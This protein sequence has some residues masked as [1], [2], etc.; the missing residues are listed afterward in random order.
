M[1][2]RLEISAGVLKDMIK[3]IENINTECIWAF[4]PTGLY[5]R[6]SD[7]YRYKLLELI[8]S[9]EDM[10]S[11]E[12]SSNGG[13][14]LGIVID[15]IKDIS[16]TLKK[17]DTLSLYYD[18]SEPYIIV[19]ANA[20]KR[21]VKLID[22]KL[23]GEPPR[24]NQ[25]NDFKVIIDS[26]RLLSFLKATSK[27]ISFDLIT[28]QGALHAISETDEGFSEMIWDKTQYPVIPI[29]SAS[30]TNYSVNEVQKAVCAAKGD[31]IVRGGM[32]IPVCFNWNIGPDSFITTM[33]AARV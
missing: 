8:L 10:I 32:D 21:K 29:D 9:K 26:P 17:T 6:M 30:T 7:V 12:F 28:T 5:I 25:I 3:A 11:Y 31:I 1:A 33:V 20:L 2:I 13:Q 27:S 24:M 16:K 19:E 18:E 4:E 22:I 15:R 14:L 23:I